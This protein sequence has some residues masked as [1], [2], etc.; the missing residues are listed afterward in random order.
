MRKELSELLSRPDASSAPQP[1]PIS[2][3]GE[4]KELPEGGVLIVYVWSGSLQLIAGGAPVYTAKDRELLLINL[5]ASASVGTGHED[6]GEVSKIHVGDALL[7]GRAEQG[8][9]PLTDYV[10]SLLLSPAGPGWLGFKSSLPT[11]NLV[12]NLL[13]WLARGEA[14]APVLE[15]FELLLLELASQPVMAPVLP[16]KQA[17]VL[18]ALREI[19]QRSLTADMTRVAQEQ[20]MSLPY[21]SSAVHAATGKTFKELLLFRR[22]EKAARFLLDT[23]MSIEEIILRV[24]YDNTSYF[25]RKFRQQFGLSPGEYRARGRKA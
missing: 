5:R 21:L 11:E 12:E 22:M 9:G 2:L 17:G 8:R 1:G 10:L 6:T 19:E 25:Y 18:A 14:S 7:R 16:V 4:A 15:T 24:G 20:G 3:L 23:S 13:Y